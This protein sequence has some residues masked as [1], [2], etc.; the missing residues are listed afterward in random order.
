MGVSAFVLKYRLLYGGA[1]EPR[2]APRE[3]PTSG[4]P[5]KFIVT[6]GLQRSVRPERPAPVVLA[7]GHGTDKVH[8][9]LT[10]WR[11][12]DESDAAAGLPS[13]SHPVISDGRLYVRNQD[14]VKVYDI[15]SSAT[16]R[17]ID[18]R[19][20]HSAAS[21]LSVTRTGEWRTVRS[22]VGL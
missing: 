20:P 9:L 16:R 6:G 22:S 1:D 10:L 13:W 14:I 5:R 15:K 11:T 8:A 2:P 12:L 7:V 21:R 17:T 4:R 18:S 3:T 19:A